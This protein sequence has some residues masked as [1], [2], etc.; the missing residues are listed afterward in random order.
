MKALL[1]QQSSFV[2][3]GLFCLFGFC[4]NQSLLTPLLS[5][6]SDSDVL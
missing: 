5:E 1:H 2:V 6:H 3:G 4:F